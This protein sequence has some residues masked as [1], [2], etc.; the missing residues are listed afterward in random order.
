[1]MKPAWLCGFWRR[2]ES[3]HSAWEVI[4]WWESRRVAYNLLVGFVGVA[5]CLVAA[6]VASVSYFLFD[7]DFGVPGSPLFALIAMAFYAVMA[8]VCYTGGWLGELLVRAAWPKQANRFATL[9]M[10]WGVLVSVLL[11][12]A[13]GILLVTLGL[14]TLIGTHL[15]IVHDYPSP[16]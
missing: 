12:A 4:G 10:S 5:S 13:P 8:N 1:M 9:T 11:T 2:D 7:S 16:E 6:V 15:G 3:P 14:L